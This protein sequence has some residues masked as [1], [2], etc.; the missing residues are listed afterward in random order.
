M[1]KLVV[2]KSKTNLNKPNINKSKAKTNINKSKAK[3]LKQTKKCVDG[4]VVNPLTN[5]CVK[6]C[7]KGFIIR[8]SYIRNLKGKKTKVLAK[9]IKSQ[10]LPGKTSDRYK[11]V[12]KG[13]GKLKKGELSKHGYT[14][15]KTLNKT[16]R[17][18]YLDSAIKE[19]GSSKI[20]K[21]LGA[22]KTYQ[23]NKSP[24]VSRILYDNMRWV[25][26]KYD[27]DFKSS[28]KDS[29]LYKL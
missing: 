10:G 8:D 19:Y 1:P 17:H 11:G 16:K 20:L 29:N 14:Q 2:K 13:I 26:K 27:A 22:V 5:R 15:I 21:K 3:T 28:W 23:K 24:E 4:K 7:P 18:K 12:N 6:K 25:R 9:C